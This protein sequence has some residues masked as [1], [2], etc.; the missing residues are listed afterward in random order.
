[1]AR[2]LGPRVY[3]GAAIHGDEVNGIAILARALSKSICNGSPAAS[4]ACLCS[5]RWRFTPTTGCRWRS[6]SDRLSIRRRPMRGAAFRERDD[7]NLAQMVAATLFRLIRY[8]DYALDTHTPTRGGR[9][10][11]IAILPYQKLGPAAQTAE[12]MA[13]ALGTGWV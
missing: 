8:C 2:T 7:R 12:Q 4:S 6:F 1:M 10:V 3:L 5:T 11:P 13:H 9:Y